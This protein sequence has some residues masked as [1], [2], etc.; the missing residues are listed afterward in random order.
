MACVTNTHHRRLFLIHFLMRFQLQDF[1]IQINATSAFSD[2][3]D[4][5]ILHIFWALGARYTKLKSPNGLFFLCPPAAS[6]PPPLVFV[7]PH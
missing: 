2:A 4:F 5:I 3:D 6:R 1:N 7:I